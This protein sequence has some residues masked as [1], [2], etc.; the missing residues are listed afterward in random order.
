MIKTPLKVTCLKKAEKLAKTWSATHVISLLDPDLSQMLIPNLSGIVKEHYIIKIFD[1]ER[2][3]VTQHFDKIINELIE[4]VE[5][6]VSD[7]DHRLLIHCHAGVSRSTAL[8]YG[9]LAIIH[10]IGQEERAFAELLNLACK[11]WPNRRIVEV[12]DNTLQ[13]KG[14]MLELLDI[15]RKRH[16]YRLDSYRRLNKKRGIPSKVE[17]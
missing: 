15:Y 11:P 12:I 17:R 1:Q 9:V 13:R 3:D 2:K 14:K 16:P 7:P 10:G 5:L 6:I 8:A 4:N